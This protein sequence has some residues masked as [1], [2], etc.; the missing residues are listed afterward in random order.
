MNPVLREGNSDRRSPLSVKA[1]SKKNPHKLGAWSATSKAHVA[2]MT[3]GNYASENSTTIKKAIDYRIE[4]VS[5][6]GATTVLKKKAPLKE[7]EI[8]DTSVMSVRALRKFYEE[9]IE[10]AKNDVLLSLHLKATMMKVSDP[11]MFGHAVTVF[12]KD[13]FDEARGRAR[14]GRREPEP[15][16]RRSTRR[17]RACRRR[18]RRRSRRTSRPS[19]RRARRSRWSTRTRASPTFTSRTT[20]SSTRPCRSSSA[21]PVRCGGRTGSSDTKAMIPDRCYATMYRR[22]SRTGKHGALNPATMG[23][24]PNVGLM[25]QQAEEYGSHDKT[26]ARPAP[27]RSGRRGREPGD[28]AQQSVE[29]ATS[30]DVPGEGRAHPRLGQ[31][32]GH[33]GARDGP[34][35]FWLDKA[36]ATR[37][38]SRRSSGT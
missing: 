35:V 25:A 38:S 33:P 7:G 37:R 12:Y 16:P 18:R 14:A 23:T 3:E 8:I 5:A 22:S 20:S 17:S 21:S 34:P 27:G 13:V 9:Q 4:F 6:D 36:R 28:A 15:R 24:V 30:S 10:D 11:V 2:C 32:R 29:R 1:F 19:T 31:A 26:F